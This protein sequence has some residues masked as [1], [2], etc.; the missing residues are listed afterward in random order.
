[1]SEDAF[2]RLLENGNY[3]VKINGKTVLYSLLE[4][5]NNR[6]IVYLTSMDEL[7][8]EQRKVM[9]LSIIV[10]SIACMLALYLAFSIADH[11]TAPIGF[12]QKR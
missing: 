10:G 9:W 2:T 8:K 3:E 7:L 6:K 5:S 11:I 12:Y 4:M 1:M